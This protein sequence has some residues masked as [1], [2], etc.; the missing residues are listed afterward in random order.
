MKTKEKGSIA[1]RGDGGGQGR[2]ATGRKAKGEVMQS[3]FE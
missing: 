2:E 3:K 1:L